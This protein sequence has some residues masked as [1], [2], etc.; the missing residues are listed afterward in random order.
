[1][2]IN[3]LDNVCA[4]EKQDRIREFCD[5]CCEELGIDVPHL[6]MAPKNDTTALGYTDMS[7]GSVT[8]VVGDRHQMDIMRTLAHELVHVRQM[9]SYEPDG[10]TGSKDENEANAMAGVLMREWGQNNPDLYTEGANVSENT[11]ESR[12]EKPKKQYSPQHEFEKRLKKK[13]GID[14][15]ANLKFY[16]DMMAKFREID[17]V[18]IKKADESFDD[19]GVP[20][21]RAKERAAAVQQKNI[22]DMEVDTAD[23]MSAAGF[24]KNYKSEG[25]DKSSD[26]YKQYLDLRKMSKQQLR[27]EIALVNRGDDVSGYDTKAGAIAQILRDRHGDRKVNKAMGLGEP[28]KQVENRSLKDFNTLSSAEYQKLKVSDKSKYTWEPN[29]QLYIKNQVKQIDESKTAKLMALIIALG[30]TYGLKDEAREFARKIQQNIEDAQTAPANPGRPDPV[31]KGNMMPGS[32]RVM[33]PPVDEIA[34]AIAA[35][36]RGVAKGVGAVA[37]GAGSMAKTAGT[38]MAIKRM[39]GDI[40][41]DEANETSTTS[42]IL[43]GAPGAPSGRLKT[44]REAVDFGAIK[45]EIEGAVR[46]GNPREMKRVSETIGKRIADLM[47]LRGTAGKEVDAEIM[48]AL[49]VLK[50]AQMMLRNKQKMSE[51]K[52]RIDKKCWKGKKIGNPKTKVKGG[53]RVNNC[54]PKE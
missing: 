7:D 12:L 52:T 32:D 34:P 54:V 5:W 14:L 13:H 49:P 15:D 51:E 37:K 46:S 9:K 42:K 24:Y 16:Q 50:K 8:I 43:K 33:R 1:M 10:A 38:K 39:Q 22:D 36:G 6:R 30:A 25:I 21:D 40:A 31:T 2:R 44:I 47:D 28:V 26:V 17:S 4:P 27:N 3:E 11:D 23:S 19:F 53:V 48:T 18:D 35:V 20:S 41:D 29:Q 45:R